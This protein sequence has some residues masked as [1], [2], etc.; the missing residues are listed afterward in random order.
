MTPSNS[1]AA[2]PELVCPLLN[3][4]TIPDVSVRSVD[5]SMFETAKAVE[6]KPAIFV[7]YRG[8]W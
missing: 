1:V 8:G 4:M 2:A 5:G 3:G 6:Q 7:F